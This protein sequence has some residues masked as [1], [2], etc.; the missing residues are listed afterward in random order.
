MLCTGLGAVILTF[1]SAEPVTAA[2]STAAPI[3]LPVLGVVF[4]LY[5][6]MVGVFIAGGAVLFV[7]ISR[8]GRD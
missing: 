7:I 3:L 5:L 2:I 4:G 1:A 8:R 6:A